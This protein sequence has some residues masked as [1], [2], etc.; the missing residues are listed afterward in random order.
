MKP[1]EIKE[2][3]KPSTREII[4]AG[5]ARPPEVNLDYMPFPNIIEIVRNL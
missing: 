4:M 2:E 5:P 3:L 1:E